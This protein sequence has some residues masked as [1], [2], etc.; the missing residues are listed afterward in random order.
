MDRKAGSWTVLA[1]GCVVSSCLHA[2][3]SGTPQAL[4]IPAP[5]AS[6]SS[7]ASSADALAL[8]LDGAKDDADAAEAGAAVDPGV[9]LIDVLHPVLGRAVLLFGIHTEEIEGYTPMFSAEGK[10]RTDTKQGYRTLILHTHDGTADVVGELPYLAVPQQDGFLYMG[11]ASVSIHQPWDRRDMLGDGNPRPHD[12][13]ATDLWTTKDS[14]AI[15]RAARQLEAKL[16]AKRAWGVENTVQLVY[17][18]PTAQCTIHTKSEVTGGALWFH[19]MTTYS[20]QSL[21]GPPIDNNLASHV[22]ERTLR[23]FGARLFEVPE[24]D[25]DFDKPYRDGFSAISWRDDVQAC[26]DHERGSVMLQGAVLRWGNSA[27]AYMT[28]RPVVP[29]P[30]SLA[31][32]NDVIDYPAVKAV[33]ADMID[34]FASPS[35]DIVL[36]VRRKDKAGLELVVWD[37][38]GRKVAKSLP[39]AGRPVMAQWASGGP[40]DAWLSKLKVARA[41]PPAP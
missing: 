11:E 6:V 34:A 10:P 4:P 16:R 12:Y 19:A 1:T 35:H 22:D 31:P 28:M 21:Q 30:P 38:A 24:E 20:L 5:S 7:D 9:R 23:Q 26:I 29:A 37:V 13:D 3:A 36:A 39:L 15:A 27:R 8:P 40:G 41:A 32:G 2:C 17:V 18:T 25:I 33:L 14:S